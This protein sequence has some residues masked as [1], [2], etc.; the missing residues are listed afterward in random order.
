V[1]SVVCNGLAADGASS[2]QSA[3]D[4]A[5]LHELFEAQA[6]MRGDAPALVCGDKSMSYA[7]LEAWANKLAHFLRSLDVGPGS[8]VGLCLERS[9]VPIV[10][11]LACLKAGAAYVPLNPSHPDERL[12]FIIEEAEVKTIL[13][14]SEYRSRLSQLGAACVV[15][16]DEQADRI[17]MQSANR[18]APAD[19]GLVPSDICYVLYTSGTTGRPKGVVAEHRNVTH[20]VLA[21]NKVCTTTPEDRVFQGFSLSFDG[22]V[23]EIWMAFSNGATLVAADRDTPRFGNEL[24]R[25][26][27]QA[28][29]TYFSTVPTLLSTM[30]E[31]I[32][33]L[34]QLVV[35]GEPCPAQLVSRWAKPGRLMLNVYGPTEATVNTTAAILKP[36]RP[37]TI[38]QPI[39]G[40]RTLILDD[41]MRPVPPGEKGELY[42][43]GPSISRGYLKQPELTSRS[44]IRLYRTGDLARVN[45]QGEL[46]FFG[47]IDGQIKL[48][49]FRIELA[50][51]EAVL[52]EQPEITSAAVRVYEQEDD[53]CLA[54]YVVLKDP[55]SPLD[56]DRI[57]ATLQARLPAYMIP[58]YLDV[59]EALPMLTTGKVD[60]KRLP[61]P[62]TPLVAR[63]A[64]DEEPATAL[65]KRIADVWCKLFKVERVGA[66]QDFFL[67]L[68]GH[69]LLAAK[70]V[71][72]L[73]EQKIDVAVRDVYAHPTVRKLAA[74]VGGARGSKSTAKRAPK[75]PS[76][77]EGRKNEPRKPGF[78]LYL[79]QTSFYLLLIP[80]LSLPLLITLPPV[81]EMLYFKRLVIDVILFLVF[82]GLCVWPILVF[83]AVA[84]KWLIIGRYKPGAYPLWGSYYM[85]WWLVS[86]L[87]AFSGLG[88]F[89]GT[90]LAP[91]IWRLMGAKVGRHCL[92]QCSPPAA[93]DLVSIGDD[94]SIGFDTQLPG[95]RI[96]D[97]YLLVGSVS[98]GKRCFVGCHSYLG[99]N[100]TLEDDAKLDDQSLL[101]DE[102]TIPAGES[103]RGAPAERGTVVVPDGAPLRQ[104]NTYLSLFCAFQILSVVLLGLA[105]GIPAMLFGFSMAFAIVHTPAWVWMPLV[106]VAVPVIIV[107]LCCYLAWCKNAIYPAPKPGT[108]ELYSFAY[109]QF[110]LTMVILR[111]V[112]A[113]GWIIF[114][115][116][117]LPPWMRLFGA[118]LGKHAEMS[119][120]W[121]LFPDLLDIGDG[122]FLADGCCLNVSRFHL[123]RYVL[124]ANRIGNRSFIGNSALLPPGSEIG[125]ECLIGVLSVPP[126]PTQPTPDRTDWLGS[127]AFQLPNRQKVGGFDER[128]TYAPT[129]KLYFQ[130]G[131]IDALR[132]LIPAYLGL[133]LGTTTFIIVL[134]L[135]NLLGVWTV[136][137]AAPVLFWTAL[138]VAVGTVVT[139]KWAVMG[140][141]KPVI[142]PL[143][144]R[145][146]WLNEMIAGIYETVMAPVV[147]LFHGTPLAAPILRLIGCKIGKHC[148]IGSDLF[149][150]FDLVEIGDYVAINDVSIVQ[151]HLFEDRIMKS[152][153][154][155]IG[156][157]CSIGNMS[158]V[159]YDTHVEEGAVLGPLSLLMKGETMPSGARWSGIPT[160]R[161]RQAG[162]PTSRPKARRSS[163][164]EH[165]IAP[166]SLSL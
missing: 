158:V 162:A 19:I 56:R 102:E 67:D 81:V 101:P 50:E 99:L 43:G 5:C 148:F 122:V 22:S 41:E 151:T 159:L 64:T 87:Q 33:S 17:T 154:A 39:E 133:F 98:I 130:R 110:W 18:L 31:D 138:A 95:I 8:F 37:I 32:P 14:K 160:V 124:K 72:A 131:V 161:A 70:L 163:S 24:A 150:E 89:G 146:V 90:P 86:R 76:A 29:V 28:G 58:A 114:T 144:S 152:S 166:E 96:E 45:E 134:G 121:S 126:D 104:S 112:R 127:P 62:A 60:R 93:W 139:I 113:A 15:A 141:F 153:Y 34:R 100:V 120:V 147:S 108:Y 116:I 128:T 9:E 52:L 136:Y 44:F 4:P 68:G 49:G 164:G 77:L 36:D 3:G 71:A 55:D 75:K 7:E 109:L 83:V 85:R 143:W 12:R 103:Y 13:T 63:A 53:A 129:P 132:I 140:T 84:S 111:V 74:L 115:T 26:L 142:V 38:G 46:E 57:L 21:F 80:L 94:S 48:R 91:L 92:L 135:Y 6:D 54:A 107:F 117:Y 73:R 51:I 25:Y 42:V 1:Q 78:G 137:A 27:A 30:T 105:L 65:E 125:E 40:Y 61:E 23:E 59:V 69:S 35:S 20:F 66:E 149:S 157:R 119:T 165:A 156:D 10:A 82:V 11:I 123:G 79:L 118:R 155:R 97:G 106:A 2:A 88:I 16:L 47:R 145:Y